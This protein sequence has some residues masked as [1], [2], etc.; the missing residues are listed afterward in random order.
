MTIEVTL[1][2]PPAS[3]TFEVG[4]FAE[5]V[6]ILSENESQ[7]IQ[8]FTLADKMSGAATAGGGEEPEAATETAAAEP[9]KERKPRAPKVEA[10]A[11]A[12][13]PVP[14]TAPDLTIPADGSV[15]GFLAR[16]AAPPAPPA[17]QTAAPPPPP[18]LPNAPPLA[19]A[20][21]T[22]ASK[23]VAHIEGKVANAA[24]G[25]AAYVIWL[26]GAGIVK[27][28][29][30]TYGEALSA[31]ALATDVQLGPVAQALGVS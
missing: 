13:L 24:D 17:P 6:A 3:T 31:V 12:P 21:P 1:S 15:P 19:P 27:P 29:A 23:V 18:P 9:K 22:L 20:A 10:V 28:G 5:A 7:L 14:T 11:P 25:G 4:S 30:V 2:R 16:P 26:Q 8:L